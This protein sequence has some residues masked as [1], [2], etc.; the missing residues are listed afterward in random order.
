MVDILKITSPISIKNRIENQ[1]SKLPTDAVF[2]INHPDQIIKELPKNEKEGD[3]ATK[4]SLLKSLNREVLELLTDSTK[5]HAEGMRKLVLMAKMFE[6]SSSAFSEGLFDR[7]FVRPQELL[8]ELLSREQGATVF[9]GEFFDSLRMLVTLDGQPKLKEAIVSLLKYFDSYVQQGNSLHAIA[10]QGEALAKLL[11][12]A[13]AQSMREQLGILET[14]IKLNAMTRQSLFSLSPDAN[15]ADAFQGGRAQG[16]ERGRST[17]GLEGTNRREII[18]F[19]KNELVPLLGVIAKR[20]RG[21]EKIYNQEMNIIHQIVR[22]DKGDPKTLEASIAQFG[23]EL[24]QLT[25]LTNEDLVDLRRQVFAQA[26]LESQMGNPP[27]TNQQFGEQSGI[28]KDHDLAS[29]LSNILDEEGMKFNGV[30]QNLLMSLIKNENPLIP[31]LHFVIPF[32]FLNEDVYGEFFIDKDSRERRGDAQNAQSIFFTI[33]S[34]QYGIFEVDLLARDKK[35]DLDIRCPDSLLSP[36]REFRGKLRD[37]IE[38][39]GFRLLHYEVGVYQESRTILQRYPKLALRK[40]GI[41]V[42]I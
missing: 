40:A 3:E 31:L 25:R 34:D 2:D 26:R 30:A 35:I 36:V 42:K 7:V 19:L 18:N 1:P 10:A 14:M 38:A 13:D 6:T 9:K 20:Y 5:A 8:G 11:S 23:D 32:R 24:K 4:Q 17:A 27:D 37:I 21:S 16:A 22:Y 39:Q 29:L 15:D 12:K 33:Q 41:D 28:E